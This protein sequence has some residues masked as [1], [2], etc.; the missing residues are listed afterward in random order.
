[1]VESRDSILPCPK[2]FFMDCHSASAGLDGIVR[3]LILRNSL[4]ICLS[5]E[6]VI[7]Q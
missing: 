7:S 3:I 2:V 4:V 5:L 6:L 1:M